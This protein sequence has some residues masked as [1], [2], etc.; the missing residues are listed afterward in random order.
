MDISSLRKGARIM[1][2][3]SIFH[4]V[5]IDNEQNAEKFING[6]IES[7]NNKNIYPKCSNSRTLRDQDTIR[8]LFRKKKA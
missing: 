3:S 5:V 4:N 6:L 7:E 8:A 2:T 1:A